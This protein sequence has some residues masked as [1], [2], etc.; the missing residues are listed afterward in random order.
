MGLR[1]RVSIAY[2]L[3]VCL[4]TSQMESMSLTM[5]YGNTE[6]RHV[7]VGRL[8][9]GVRLLLSRSQSANAYN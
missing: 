2:I 6:I 8:K 9:A 4:R 7:P 3:K 1:G 5:L